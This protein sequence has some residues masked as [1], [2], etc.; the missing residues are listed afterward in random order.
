MKTLRE[1][2][3]A[4]NMLLADLGLVLFTW[5]NASAADRKRGRIA[6]KPSGVPYGELT[7]EHMVVLDFEGAVVSGKHAPS[8]DTP[9]HLALYTAFADI[10]GVVH[11]H[12]RWA[13]I[14][15]QAGKAI[16]ALGTT[17]AD[18]FDGPVPCARPLT[19][20]ETQSGYEA[21]T[22]KAIAEAFQNRDPA[23]CPAALAAHHGPFA[24]GPDAKTAAYTARV[25]EEVAMTAWHTLAL[26]PQAALPAHLLEK[27]F[28]RK[29]G[30]DA[31]YGQR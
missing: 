20:R 17:H 10:G 18:H 1:E 28:S 24:W 30:P 3:Y 25:L 9:S 27:H 13:T 16:P 5:G 8:S 23:C 22:G 4:A 7:P 2:A 14:W 15:A 26:N 12:S 29:H 6:I 19:P 31:Y 11:T 21:A